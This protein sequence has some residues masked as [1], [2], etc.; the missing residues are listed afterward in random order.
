MLQRGQPI[1]TDFLLTPHLPRGEHP[2]AFDAIS[3][4]DYG[5]S[6]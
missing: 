3:E 2:P 5:L 6:E 1:P 4:R